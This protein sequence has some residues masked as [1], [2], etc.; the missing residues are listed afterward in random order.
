M[1]WPGWEL[2][3]VP[4][5]V[6]SGKTDRQILREILVAAGVPDDR[7]EGAIAV[8]LVEAEACLKDSARR[9]PVEGRVH[10]GVPEALKALHGAGAVQSVVTGN[11]R[12]NARVKLAAFGL[13]EH[14]DL[15][16]G[17]FGSD[18][19]DRNCLVPLCLDRAALRYGGRF[20]PEEVWVTA[21]PIGTW[22]APG[23][24]GCAACWS[25]LG[26]AASRKS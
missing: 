23:P 9:L 20:D 8:G 25:E 6:M 7:L 24:R 14:L 18:D 17:A 1:G 19:E 21:T 16:I 13:D 15:D 2:A 5:V 10:P 4:K 12:A 26:V 3:A 22:T 11:L